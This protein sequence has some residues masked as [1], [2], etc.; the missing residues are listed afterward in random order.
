MY[1]GITTGCTTENKSKAGFQEAFKSI[2][3]AI[4]T[5]AENKSELLEM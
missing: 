1:S 4:R 5:A 2:V 3:L